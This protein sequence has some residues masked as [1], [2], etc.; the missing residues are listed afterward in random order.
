MDSLASLIKTLNYPFIGANHTIKRNRRGP[1][2]EPF[3]KHPWR[4][5]RFVKKKNCGAEA[6]HS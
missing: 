6:N 4:R 3:S 2:P 1:E 5:S